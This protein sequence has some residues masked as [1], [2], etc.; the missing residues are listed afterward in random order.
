MYSDVHPMYIPIRLLKV[1]SQLPD[2]PERSKPSMFDYTKHQKNGL[3][4]LC[5]I[6]SNLKWVR[7]SII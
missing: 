4:Q 3:D 6:P 2:L 5:M 7:I 1:L